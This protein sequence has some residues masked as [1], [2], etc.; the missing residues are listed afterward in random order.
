MLRRGGI[1]EAVQHFRRVAAGRG[2]TVGEAEAFEKINAVYT[3]VTTIAENIAGLPFM[4]STRDERV[5]ESGPL[6]DLMDQ[7]N[8]TMSQDGFW[9]ET[10]GWYLLTGRVH[11]VFN[12]GEYRSGR[13]LSITPVGAGQMKPVTDGPVG[14]T[15]GNLIAWLYREPGQ[16]WDEARRLELDAVWTVRNPSFDPDRPYEGLSPVNVV[17][18]AIAQLYKADVA[19]EASL[20]NGVE[21]GGALIHKGGLLSDPQRKDLRHE[22]AERHAG[23]R[24]R[25]RPL[26]LMGDWDWKQISS[27]F[28]D[29]EFSQLKL[30]SRGEICAA[31]KL[32]H[33][34][35]F[36]PSTGTSSEYVDK[37]IEKIWTDAVK[38][39]ANRFAGEFDRGVLSKFEADPSIRMHRSIVAARAMDHAPWYAVRG[40]GTTR[41]RLYAWFDLSGVDALKS[42]HRFKIE[43]GSIMRRELFETAEHVGKLMDLGLSGNDAQQQVMIP[44]NVVP[45]SSLSSVMDQPP[46]SPEDDPEDDGLEDGGIGDEPQDDLERSSLPVHIRALS[47]AQLEELQD[48]W[49]RS[50]QPTADRLA[51]EL[52]AHFFEQYKLVMAN[53]NRLAPEKSIQQRDL[54]GQVLFSVANARAALAGRALPVIEAAFQLGGDQ[55]RQQKAD[56]DGVPVEDVDPFSI[57]DPRVAEAIRSRA[58]MISAVNDTAYDRLRKKLVKLQEAGEPIARFGEAAAEV[59]RIDHKRAMVTARTEIGASVEKANHLGREQQG[60]PA[61]SWLS[62]RKATSR[63]NHTSVERATLSEPIPLDQNFVIPAGEKSPGGTC[64]HPRDT[65]LP[66]GEVV[67]CACTTISRYPGDTIRDARLITALVE[68]G[69]LGRAL[70]TGKDN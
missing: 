56:A 35:L 6:A 34:A 66:A 19:N 48:S 52:R 43:T 30:I 11:W 49:F 39:H 13:P 68:K 10:V 38:S 54:V 9:H 21:P 41:R 26:L 37:A 29:M 1:A 45:Y 47:P 63:D 69:W 28:S 53:I 12:N 59:L 57:R 2:D 40:S 50:W 23:P 8:A 18:R 22:M 55:I 42:L 44:T 5:I 20:D 32:P 65:S 24:N 7:P 31:F 16:R 58:N 46:E 33:A 62:S 51:G 17:R 4:V 61:K 14:T 60:V 64:Q 36:E 15:R 27:S 3:C 70:A 67:N 25:R